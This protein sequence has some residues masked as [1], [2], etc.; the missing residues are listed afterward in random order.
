MPA[1]TNTSLLDDGNKLIEQ[2]DYEGAVKIF[3][4]AIAADP[5]N[6]TLHYN[7]GRAHYYAQKYVQA[8]S[9]FDVVVKSEP[10]NFW[11]LYLRANCYYHTQQYAPALH[12]AKKAVLIDAASSDANNLCGLCCYFLKHYNA[13]TEYYRQ[14]ITLNKKNESAFN[15]YALA[16]EAV[17]DNNTAAE[18]YK[19][20]LQINPSFLVAKA[21]LALLYKKTADYKNALPLVNELISA[22]P[23]NP[24]H[25]N[26]IGNIF[27]DNLQYEEAIEAYSKALAAAPQFVYACF[28]IGLCHLA[29]NEYE[30]ALHFFNE[31]LVLQ[32]GYLPAMQQKAVALDMLD[33]PLEAIKLFEVIYKKVATD[34]QALND[35]LINWGITL[36]RMQRYDEAM[37]K[38]SECL[39]HN[40]KNADA[41]HNWGIMLHKKGE[42]ALAVDKY[43]A[44]IAIQDN[45]KNKGIFFQSMGMAYGQLNKSE[46][47]IEAYKNSIEQNNNSH[48]LYYDLAGEQANLQFFDDAIESLNTSI[49][50]NNAYAYAYHNKAHYLRMQ[51]NYANAKITAQKA[52]EIYEQTLSNFIGDNKLKADYYFYYASLYYETTQ[53]ENKTEALLSNGIA[54]NPLHADILSLFTK[55]YLDKSNNASQKTSIEQTGYFSK[56]WQYYKKAETALKK[57]LQIKKTASAFFLLAQHQ[58][59]L[60]HFLTDKDIEEIENNY[61][62]ALKLNNDMHE[63]YNGLALLYQ[64]QQ[65]YTAAI[66][67]FEAAFIRQP[68]NIIYRNNLAN[69][70]FLNKQYEKAEIA[71]NKVLAITG[72]HVEAHM[73]LGE[74]YT[75][76]ADEGSERYYDTAVKAYT[77]A[78]SVSRSGE[79]SKVLNDKE[80]ARLYYAKAYAII[81]N[82]ENAS[83]F[84]ST[85]TIYKAL[86]DL[87]NACRYDKDLQVAKRAKDAIRKKMLRNTPAQFAERVGPVI[88]VILSIIVFVY[89]QANFWGSAAKKITEAVYV[90][91][92][93]GSLAFLIAG[94]SLPQLLKLKVAGIELEKSSVDA[95]ASQSLITAGSLGLQPL[96]SISTA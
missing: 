47:A 92:S 89:A 59:S 85:K 7:A 57:E 58:F 43:N 4:A 63:V 67:N 20:A 38:F 77:K 24:K 35:L 44:A 49:K 3:E 79:G 80:I 51:G 69:A 62:Q 22:E 13:A 16:L 37:V 68:Q 18:M 55:L 50:I 11:G 53:D 71:L 48:L 70:Y 26:D 84:Q 52:L 1:L 28:N 88:V 76:M 86:D 61:Q 87:K 96:S 64:H 65:K 82:N 54:I 8:K 93:F 39:L 81:K 46:E 32:P 66:Q 94:L 83:I 19:S 41:W 2:H 42:Y 72:K 5:G 34:K 90:T 15:N 10:E 40:H 33:K 29:K 31:A 60:L 75:A 56:A 45:N 6:I 74:L 27:Y 21:N 23:H 36:D 73:A 12:D 91:L 17:G 95:S 25:Y 14:A 78:I 30:K 9:Y